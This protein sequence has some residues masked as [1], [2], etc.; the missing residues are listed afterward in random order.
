MV[1]DPSRP[2]N[3]CFSSALVLVQPLV[4][5]PAVVRVDLATG[6]RTILSDATHGVGTNLANPVAITTDPAQGLAYVLDPTAGGL[7]SVDLATGDRLRVFN[8]VVS[9][10]SP[11]DI[12]FLPDSGEVLILDAALRSLSAAS[13]AGLSLRPVSGAGV[14][15]GPDF[16]RPSALEFVPATAPADA[17]SRAY[18]TDAARGSVYAVDL[19]TGERILRTK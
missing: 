12:A 7:L 18:V 6:N 17:T 8:L 9:G 14:G 10:G 1:L 19:V 13:L 15:A 4:D 2:A 11:S 3:G 5:P 16:G